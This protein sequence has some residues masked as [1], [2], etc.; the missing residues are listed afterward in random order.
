MRVDL[1]CGVDIVLDSPI[2]LLLV[3][4]LLCQNQTYRSLS[5]L[6]IMCLLLVSRVHAA[7]IS[8][9]PKVQLYDELSPLIPT[10]TVSHI[11]SM[12]EGLLNHHLII[13]AG[14]DQLSYVS[15]SN[16]RVWL[17]HSLKDTKGMCLKSH[18]LWKKLK[19]EGGG[20]RTMKLYNL[21]LIDG[22]GKLDVTS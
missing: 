22:S 15:H 5:T 9:V 2:T 12:A 8:G 20:N 6:Y 7:G 14:I 11:Q 4:T 17:V 21:S 19:E 13:Q 3:L 16:S 1:L 10:L 18:M